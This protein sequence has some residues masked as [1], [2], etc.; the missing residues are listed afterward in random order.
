MATLCISAQ[1]S[2]VARLATRTRCERRRPAVGSER[3]LVTPSIALG[4]IPKDN[5]AHLCGV[6]SHVQHGRKLHSF[7]V[8]RPRSKAATLRASAPFDMCFPHESLARMA[9][10]CRGSTFHM[11]IF[12]RE[13]TIAQNER[14]TLHFCRNTTVHAAQCGVAEAY[15]WTVSG[16]ALE[17]HRGAAAQYRHMKGEAAASLCHSDALPETVQ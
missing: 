17:W 13:N 7:M 2:T 6:R 16:N 3:H 8:L 11:S 12:T 5:K 10:R 9:Q 1:D 14:K 15:Y 4:S